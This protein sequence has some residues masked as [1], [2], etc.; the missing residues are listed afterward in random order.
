MA[1]GG[2]IGMH[3][4]IRLN[5]QLVSEPIAPT[6][7]ALPAITGVPEVGETL[8]ATSGAWS[9]RPAEYAYQWYADGV[10]I[11]DET[12]PTLL[13]LEGMV[14]AIITVGAT[15]TNAAGVSDEALS[16]Y[17]GPIAVA[18]AVL[19]LRFE[20]TDDTLLAD[21]GYRTLD[22]GWKVTSNKARP[23]A[24]GTS[25][26]R[27]TDVTPMGCAG[28]F[29]IDIVCA[30]GGSAFVGLE[31][32]AGK[33]CIRGYINNHILTV[34][35]IDLSNYPVGTP[36]QTTINTLTLTT[37]APDNHSNVTDYLYK[38]SR[39]GDTITFTH[40]LTGKSASGTTTMPK[41]GDLALFSNNTLSSIT[42]VDV[43]SLDGVLNADVG[44]GLFVN[45]VT[46]LVKL[47][48]P[49]AIDA[50]D[51]LGNGLPAIIVGRSTNGN[52]LTAGLDVVFYTAPRTS[53]KVTIDQNSDA[54]TTDRFTKIEGA[55]WRQI[56]G[57]WYIFVSDQTAPAQWL[58]GPVTAEGA[59]TDRLQLGTYKRA[60]DCLAMDIADEN[61]V[62]WPCIVVAH[63][64]ESGGATPVTN[65]IAA[66][67]IVGYRYTG[68]DVLDAGSWSAFTI[69][70]H[71]GACHFTKTARE[72]IDYHTPDEARDLVFG[73]RVNSSNQNGVSGVYYARK[74]ASN[75]D[76]F[77]NEWVGGVAGNGQSG[78]IYI[79]ADPLLEIL[80]PDMGDFSGDGNDR[81]VAFCEFLQWPVGFGSP[82]G[83]PAE[84]KYVRYS[85]ASVVS[86]GEV[87]ASGST[88]QRLWNVWRQPRFSHTGID[89]VGI[90]VGYQSLYSGNSADG[91]AWTWAPFFPFNI[92][93]PTEKSNIPTWEWPDGT[94]H[95]FHADSSGR[96]V[97]EAIYSDV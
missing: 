40:V 53:Y 44:G 97:L 43:Y 45:K 46:Q 12:D 2:S 73:A 85:N 14:G 62:V 49:D 56:N 1:F 63:E 93:H 71:R 80:N 92:T 95:Q 16:D 52:G 54:S 41:G 64:G 17:F 50:A 75:V 33:K 19:S 90:A 72:L 65:L 21:M 28:D 30:P 35:E 69:L 32:F 6:N 61:G 23:T 91:T 78:E 27:C 29:E 89:R 88:D 7:T 86:M 60:Q 48:D 57:D 55:C 13:I 42:S 87:S 67:G 59:T 10:E 58:Y 68:G 4:G 76:P 39:V 20:E 77:T 94:V 34:A 9:G 47:R 82:T 26:M 38:F 36:T 37:S 18:G 79:P 24:A 74:P 3:V 83:I 31:V 51:V 96:D 66:G 84:P 8:T 11:E 5:P 70:R 15:A 25:P 22:S 81:D